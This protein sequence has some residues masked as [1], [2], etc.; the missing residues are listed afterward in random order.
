MMMNN[1]GTL[2]THEEKN[3]LPPRRPTRPIWT[4]PILWVPLIAVIVTAIVFSNIA[5]L[6]MPKPGEHSVNS[7]PTL[8]QAMKQL[9]QV[10]FD[11]RAGFPGKNQINI[12]V[13]GIDDNW[14]DQNTLYTKNARTDTLF[15]L[16]LDLANKKAA[17]L[18]VPRD[19]YVPIAGTGTSDKINSAYASGG[20]LRSVA[21]F[22]HLTDVFPDYYIVLN[23]DATK[24]LV[25]ALGGVDLNVE[26]QM[27]Y[28][29]NWGHLHVHLMP[30]F[31]HLDGDQALSFVRYRHGNHG[32]A[33]ED[34]DPRRIYRQHVLMRAMIDKAKT[35]N[36]AANSDALVNTAMSCIITNLSRTQIAD[37]AHLFQGAQQQDIRIAQLDGADARGPDGA[38]LVLLDPV[39]VKDYV[40]WLVKGNEAAV[41]RITPVEVKAPLGQSNTAQTVASQLQTAGFS[42]AVAEGSTPAPTAATAVVD[43]GVE[44][45]EAAA[46][47]ASMLGLPSSAVINRPNQPNKSGWT[48]PAQIT[49]LIGAGTAT[50]STT[51]PAQQSSSHG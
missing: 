12:L 3:E 29:D 41:W 4:R 32:L 39:Q 48:A 43:T 17:M 35:F 26:H 31:Q 34:G 44:D 50:A 1:P 21:T 8:P 5:R 11:P 10:V 42:E 6:L 24:R 49:V 19:S 28:D 15:L 40:D 30:G 37:L 9:S 25:D 18:S 16:T 7:A 14:T 38:W 2:P 47:L 20:P 33:P 45:T 22:A 13:M 51:P 46:H 23:I 36:A 27:D